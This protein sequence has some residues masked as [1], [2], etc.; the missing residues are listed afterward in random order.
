[1]YAPKEWQ[2]DDV[3][4]FVDSD[5]YFQR[6]FTDTELAAFS[7]V[8]PGE[9]LASYNCPNH[10]QTLLSE[11]GDLF[12]KKPMAQIEQLLPGMG[13]M[14][15]RNWGFVVATLATWRELHRRTV[16]I[17]PIVDACF[18][19][20]ARVQL[21]CLYAVQSPG[22]TLSELPPLAHH[23]GHHSVKTGLTKDNDVW[24]LNGEVVAF[25][26]AL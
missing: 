9:L 16:A 14:R 20:P 6:P 22:M 2:D 4:I 5:A 7:A 13:E 18:D 8:A 21:A 12:P 19:N 17:W 25:A 15:C 3:V 1:M 24:R 10:E 26:H 23:H 11:A